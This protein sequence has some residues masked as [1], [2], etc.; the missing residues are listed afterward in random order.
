MI[1][2]S[3]LNLAALGLLAAA[4]P[5][6]AQAPAASISAGMTVKD[7]AGGVV[8]TVAGV[9][10]QYLTVKT[11]RNEVRLPVTSFTPV[12][13]ALLFGMTR[14]QL[15]AEVD[16]AKAAADA[17]VVV[18]AAVTGAGGASVGTIEALDGEFVTLKLTSGA[19]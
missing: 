14:D 3:L 10:G 15:N 16:K 11:D 9:D 12:D 8:G 18:G 2:K 4:A 13:G 6:A 5:V 1:R 19:S 17:K 7:T